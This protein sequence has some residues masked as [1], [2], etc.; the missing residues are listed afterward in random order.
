MLTAL[1]VLV[2]LGCALA[3]LRRVQYAVAPTALSPAVLL[4][5][6]R[7]ESG[8]ARYPRVREAMLADPAADWERDLLHALE[9][10]APVRAA[11]VNEQL[12]ELDYRLQRWARVPRVCASI[13]TSAGFLLGTWVLRAG[14]SAASAGPDDGRGDLINA[15]VMQAVNVAVFGMA[16]AAFCIAAQVRAQKATKAFEQDA[17]RLVERLE[18]LSA[19]PS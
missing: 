4:E 17:D 7:G 16:G 18:R 6:L 9:S 1:A 15:V 5:A 12:T 10:P 19:P 3:S 13:A 2:A 8:R 11:L 14:L